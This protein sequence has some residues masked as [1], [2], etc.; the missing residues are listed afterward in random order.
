VKKGGLFYWKKVKARQNL[1]KLL[2]TFGVRP[3]KRL[4][5]RFLVDRGTIKKIIQAA[6][7]NLNDT[8]LE[9]GP[10]PGALTKELVKKSKK[11]IA[12]E[13]DPRMCQILGK[14]LKDFK[15]VKIIRGDILNLL[16]PKSE[17]R[18][19]KQIPN[20]K[21]QIPKNYKVVANLPFYI[22]APVIRKFLESK[23]PPKEM[24]LVVQKEIARRI[25]PR[26]P[27]LKERR[28]GK[29]PNMNLLAVSVQFYAKPE[30][31]SYIS[32]KSFWPVPKVDSAIIK[33]TPINTNQNTNQHKFFKVVKA[34]FL[35][36]RKQLI[37]NFSEGLKIKKEKIEKWLLENRVRPEQRAES[38]SINDWLNL[39][40][41]LPN[42]VVALPDVV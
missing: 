10:G 23:T 6:E 36:P 3:S 18:N 9:I 35:H 28:R 34:G 21:F 14:E 16:N 12:V 32:K 39:T 7:I 29:S 41:T 40:K 4:A 11:V 8:V 26:P 25:C 13:K 24:I 5:Q 42:I 15:N 22:T 30:I 17:I 1:K 19:P 2:K 27:K 20:S 31:I 37:N 33:I 38:L